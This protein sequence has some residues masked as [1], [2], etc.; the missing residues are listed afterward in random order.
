[1]NANA[2]ANET[3]TG[4]CQRKNLKR[5]TRKTRTSYA[6]LTVEGRT[7]MDVVPPPAVSFVETLVS[8]R[9][10]LDPFLHVEAL[11]YVPSGGSAGEDQGAGGGGEPLA[12]P[13]DGA[14]GGAGGHFLTFGLSSRN[15]VI[16]GSAFLV[17]G[18]L[19]LVQPVLAFRKWCR[20]AREDDRGEG[21]F[22]GGRGGRGGGRRGDGGRMMVPGKG[23]G[24]W[25]YG[26]LETEG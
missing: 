13:E 25:R 18:V 9:S 11:T 14:G 21:G 15:C 16:V 3:G 22:G 12:A 4:M 5:G 6:V 10:D 1:M 20:Q 19:L 2:N 24:Q 8:V 17:V 23:R 7:A 26:Q